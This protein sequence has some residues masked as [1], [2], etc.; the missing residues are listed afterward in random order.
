MKFLQSFVGDQ[1]ST[2]LTLRMGQRIFKEGQTLV[3]FQIDRVVVGIGV[4]DGVTLVYMAC[5]TTSNMTQKL[6]PDIS[7]T[8]QQN[9]LFPGR[10]SKLEVVQ[11]LFHL[12][13]VVFNIA[14]L[15]AQS[16]VILA[17]SA[18][19]SWADRFL[20]IVALDAYFLQVRVGLFIR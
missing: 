6:G 2:L 8:S 12:D 13:E 3:F 14:I 11:P 10:T 16:L 20:L 9:L 19:V 7:R 17:V 4:Q 5:L 1:L 15:G 18:N